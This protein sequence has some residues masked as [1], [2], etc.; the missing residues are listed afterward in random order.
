LQHCQARAGTGAA[1][2]LSALWLAALK[3]RPKPRI[4]IRQN[5]LGFTPEKNLRLSL[6]AILALDSLRQNS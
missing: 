4:E 1:A 6:L 2:D 5:A 3:P